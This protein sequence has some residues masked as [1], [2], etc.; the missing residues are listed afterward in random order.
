[1]GQKTARQN[2][3]KTEV[4]NRVKEQNVTAEQPGGD[5]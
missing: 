4:E 2:L 5:G 1:M 3:F